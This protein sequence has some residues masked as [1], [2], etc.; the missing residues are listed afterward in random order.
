MARSTRRVIRR[1][2]EKHQPDIT[3]AFL[4]AVEDIIGRVRI[5]DVEDLL[6]AGR[7]DDVLSLLDASSLAFE[8]VAETVID[9]Y[10]DGGRGVAGLVS[11]GRSA[12]AIRA[13]FRF[14][15]RN[16]IAETWI[17]QTS[18]RLVQDISESVRAGIRGFL[19]D[20]LARG[21]N[22]RRTALDLVGRISR[23]SNR[24]AGG[25]IGLTQTQQAWVT[26][27]RDQLLSNDPQKL[28]AYLKRDLRDKRFDRTVMK[29]IRDG[30]PIPRA[31]IDDITG[32]YADRVLKYRGD[33]IART[34]TIQSLNAGQFESLRQAIAGG[35]VDEEAIT[36]TWRSARDG[37]VRAS[38]KVLHGV[39]TSFLGVY[40]TILG[41]RMLF[42]GDT[43]Q[44]ADAGDIIHCR[45]ILEIFIDFARGIR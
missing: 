41:S 2:L 17:S 19:S 42:P 28:K 3:R 21:D 8:R 27:A 12:P 9:A 43:S 23:T 45:C 32:R 44:G 33:M 35:A 34:E 24:R 31:K 30:Q 22:P 6:R 18:S 1:L 39:K 14:D 5:Q 7:I 20:G 16:L 37:R 13:S 4:E 38:H 25:I 15:V 36:K 29:A 26:S 10:V 11:E 40:E